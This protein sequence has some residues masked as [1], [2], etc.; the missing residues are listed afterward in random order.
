MWCRVCHCPLDRI[1][2]RNGYRHRRLD[3]CVGSIDVAVPKLRVGVLF[4]D[5]LLE[6]RSRSER[7][8]TTVIVTCYLKGVCT[9]R[10]NDLVAIVGIDSLSKS[11]VSKMATDLGDMVAGFRTWLLGQGPYYL[12]FVRR[13]NCESARG[14]ARC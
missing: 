5:W 4:P 13:A 9:C 12:R 3:T 11:Q 8:L 14:R 1:N 10:M 2:T 6:R 7:A